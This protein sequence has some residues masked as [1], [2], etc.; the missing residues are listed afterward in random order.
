MS[1]LLSY[2]L[3]D[4]VAILKM[5]D[6]KANALSHEMLGAI[7]ESLD[8]AEKEAK[9]LLLVGREGKFCAGFDLKT[10][11]SGIDAAT[12]LVTAGADMYMRLYAYRLPVVAACTGHA[13]AGG[14]LL[15]L[16]SDTRVG[17]D[18]PFKIGLN[19]VSI[20]MTLPVLAQELA[21]DRLGKRH[22]T[23]AT[24]QAKVYTPDG[25]A[26]A[27]Y[28]DRLAGAESV[29]EEAFAE[30]KRLSQLPGEAYGNT[31]A[32]LREATITHIRETLAADMAAL[33]PS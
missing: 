14:A 10:M 22:L 28:L 12:K 1:E 5:D 25:A 32:K 11:M 21:R 23:E 30:A 27:G 31:K 33:T 6:G 17:T 19:E 13:L 24:M 3:R 26:E 9:A 7:H 16:V 8:R 2:E 15:L 29:V 18:G 4:H 20:G